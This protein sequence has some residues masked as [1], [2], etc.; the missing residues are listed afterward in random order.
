MNKLEVK[1]LLLS[2]QRALW[3]QVYPEVR[4]IAIGY[5][6]RVLRIIYYLDR[7]PNSSDYEVVSDVA[8]E[9]V[10]DFPYNLFKDVKEEC[11]YSNDLIKNLSSLDS[12]LYIR[13]E[14]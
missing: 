1:D 6:N 11:V 4:A 10:S 12:F 14:N 7:E 13:K 3:G 9:I 2:G 5:K 8:G